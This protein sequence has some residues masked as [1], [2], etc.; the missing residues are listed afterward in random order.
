MGVA[1]PS[2]AVW[3]DGAKGVKI[4]AT[5]TYG[6]LS[7]TMPWICKAVW[8][9][10]PKTLIHVFMTVQNDIGAGIIE[11]PPEIVHIGIVTMN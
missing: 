5:C 2:F 4:A 10:R 8:I 6:K 3:L 1:V 11:Q 9:L 7:N